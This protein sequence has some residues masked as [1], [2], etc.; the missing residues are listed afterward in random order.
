[1]KLR[2]FVF[3]A[4]VLLT[5]PLASYAQVGISVNIAPPPLPVVEQPPAPAEGYIWTPGYWGY[6]SDYYW[7][8]GAWVAP[9]TV[10]VLWT[11]AWWGWNNGAY[12]FNEGYWGPTVG[13]YGGINYGRGYWGEGIRGGVGEETTF[14][15]IEVVADGTKPSF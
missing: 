6:E 4:F 14:G 13:F 1:M 9:P 2:S 3:A 5:M 11:P 7:V 12:A 15:Y 10:G 8:P